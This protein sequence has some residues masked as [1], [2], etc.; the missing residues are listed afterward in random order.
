[1][2]WKCGREKDD[3]KEKGVLWNKYMVWKGSEELKM[4][5]LMGAVILLILLLLPFKLNKDEH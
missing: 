5:T 2:I 4:V 1:M 3:N